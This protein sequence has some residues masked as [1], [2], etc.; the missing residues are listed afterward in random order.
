LIGERNLLYHKYEEEKNIFRNTNSWTINYT[1]FQQVDHIIYETLK[2]VYQIPKARAA[3]FGEVIKFQEKKINIPLIYWDKRKQLID[4]VELRRRNLLGD[5]WYEVL[6]D[7]LNSE[8]MIKIGNYLRDRRTK[9]IV[10]PDEDKVFRAYKFSS[11]IHT[12]VV[13]LGQDPYH[14]GSANGLAF[15]FKDDSKKRPAKSL[16]VIFKE[17]E[18][19]C[20]NGMHLDFDNTLIPWAQQGV[21]LLNTVLTV[22][23]GKPKSHDEMGWQRFIKIT[24]YELLKDPAPKVYMLWGNDAINLFETVFQALKVKGFKLDHSLVLKAR[25]PAADLYAADQFGNTAPDFPNTY[26]G[27]RHFNK[28]NEFLLKNKRKPITW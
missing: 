17:V 14:D 3:E 27:C 10:Y 6:K 28:A 12:K 5:S 25:H 23:R 21:L 4:K 2:D 24:I 22:E 11:F 13:I 9:T 1:I 7:V 20:Y 26:A 18:R 19:D 16:D 15:G 8:Y